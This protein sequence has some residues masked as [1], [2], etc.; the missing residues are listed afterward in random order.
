MACQSCETFSDQS[1]SGP[2][3]KPCTSGS[4]TMKRPRS[5]AESATKAE[6]ALIRTDGLAKQLTA[7]LDATYAW[8]LSAGNEV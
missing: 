7:A 1:L 2:Y 3:P 5:C 4:S 8:M 6:A